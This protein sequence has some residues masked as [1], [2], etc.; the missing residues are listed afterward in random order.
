MLRLIPFLLLLCGP[1]FA[2]DL[3]FVAAPGFAFAGPGLA[4]GA[5]VWIP[6]TYGKDR[7][8]PPDPPDYVRRESSLEMDIWVFNRDRGD[9]PLDRGA[10][11]LAR[12]LRGLRD[13]GY[14]RIID[15][16]CGKGGLKVL[17]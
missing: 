8:G 3:P 9:D 5:L 6:G 2:A 14:R 10:E 16:T 1:V 12:G 13:E 11:T 4:M 15:A 7:S 17:I